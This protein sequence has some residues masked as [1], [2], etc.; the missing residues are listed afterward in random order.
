M[1]TNAKFDKTKYL[2]FP[3]SKYRKVVSS[4]CA[5]VILVHLSNEPVWY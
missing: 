1:I 2:E 4:N 5:T 3:T